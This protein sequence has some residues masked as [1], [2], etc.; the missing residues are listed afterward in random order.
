[1][2]TYEYECSDC[3]LNVEIQQ[4]IN[5]KKLTQCPSCDKETF[6]RVIGTPYFSVKPNVT[7][8]GQ[9]AE[10]NSQKMGKE[11]VA[12]AERAREAQSKAAKAQ[13]RREL[14]KKL[15]PGCKIADDGKIEKPW[16]GELP[17]SLNNASQQKLEKYI[18]TGEE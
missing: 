5:D 9:L 18:M 10:R 12:A 3:G 11:G 7:T 15:P 16:Y 6:D 17:S 14:Q 13:M 1:M 8:I 4:S 2:I